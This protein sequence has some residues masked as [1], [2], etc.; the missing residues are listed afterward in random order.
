[1]LLYGLHS[2]CSLEVLQHN[3]VVVFDKIVL[4]LTVI[5][6]KYYSQLLLL[7]SNIKFITI[8]LT[9]V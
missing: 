9:T 3:L 4:K 7:H 5:K 8:L 1:M 6:M 2:C